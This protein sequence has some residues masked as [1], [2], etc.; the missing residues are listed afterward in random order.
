MQATTRAFLRRAGAACAAAA[1]LGGGTFAAGAASA[2]PFSEPA[3]TVQ[4]SAAPSSASAPAA[5]ASPSA[6]S[7]SPSATATS[8][9]PSAGAQPAGLEAALKRDLGQTVAGFEANGEL[10][11]K[12][13]TIDAEVKK[14]DPNAAVSVA[15]DTI[16]VVTSVPAAANQAAKQAGVNAKVSIAP[17]Q[18]APAYMVGVKK[19]DADAKTLLAAYVHAFGARNLQSIMVN[20]A[21]QHVIRTSD[22]A[23]GST[24]PSFRSFAA[25]SQESVTDFAAKYN[26]VVVEAADGPAATY[27]GDVVN[28]Q[29]YAS[30]V[31]GNHYE[32]CSIGWNGFDRSGRPA[33]ISAGHCTADGA[34]K[35][36]MLT[37]PVHDAAGRPAGPGIALLGSLGTFGFSQF[38]GPGNSPVTGLTP[39]SG[40]G[41]LGN[42]GT[43]VSVID[44]IAPG[45][46][47][48]PLATHW[49][50]P[51]NLPATATRVTGVSTAVVGAEICKSARTTGW[52]CGTVTEVGIFLVGGVPDPTNPADVRAVWGFGSDNMVSGPGDSGGAVISGTTAVGM[53]SAGGTDGDGTAWTFSTDLVDAL[54]HTNGYTVKIFLNSPTLTSPANNGTVHRSAP[55]TGKVAGAPA[56]TTVTATVGGRTSTVPVGANG[57]WA[58]KAPTTFG[59]FTLTA[60]AGSGFSTSAK[61][62]FK[63]TVIRQTLAAPAFTS[64]APNGS[65]TAPVTAVSGTG[66]P[67]ATVVLSGSVTGTAVVGAGGRWSVAASPT[68]TA[69]RYSV[70]ARQ[71]LADW[72]DSAA[73]TAAFRVALPAPA[74]TTRHTAPAPGNPDSRGAPAA[75]AALLGHVDGG[76]L[77]ETGVP[78]TAATVGAAGALLLL[79][80]AAFLLFGRRK[81][82]H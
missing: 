49:T 56:G 42:I 33:V 44:N 47:Q 78:G 80:G 30:Q 29:G 2:A 4:S 50:D 12:A 18:A 39:T 69:G 77:A 26:N 70:T 22:P 8:A 52:T 59:S 72:N 58:I 17:V 10:A 75:A 81:R 53:I 23:N 54:A 21:G 37:D 48:L 40:P 41:D 65:A 25:A 38:G 57:T 11:A 19:K 9:A 46:T 64:P 15:G 32:T 3:P 16:K 61:A 20:A 63:V 36:P 31:S 76:G 6:A 71:T 1:I 27:G 7:A 74:A 13:A 43:D 67:G 45:L 55:I 28:G 34:L 60:R 82:T 73:A 5:S 68:L 24:T 35:D 66:K 62:T 51:S 79:A 14:A